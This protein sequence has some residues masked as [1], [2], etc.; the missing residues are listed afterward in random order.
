MKSLH[1]AVVGAGPAGL[2]A[3]ECLAQ[4]GIIVTL[5]DRM[6]SPARKFLL[7]GRGGLNLTHSEAHDAFLTRYGEAHPLMARALQRF[8]PIDLR[9]WAA[10]LGEETFIGSS[11][12]VFP[13]SFKAS[14]LLRAWLKRLADQGVTLATRHEF[15]GF[16]PEGALRFKTPAGEQT[17]KADAVLLALG[18]ASWPRLGADGSW[19]PLLSAAGVTLHPFKPANAGWL[20]PWSAYVRRFAGTPLKRIAV[21]CQGETVRGDA[22][23]TQSG[24]EGG[25]IYALG[26][27]MR[28]ALSASQP[29][30]HLDLRPDLAVAALASKLGAMRQGASMAK[31][32]TQAGL[33]PAMQAI[34]REAGPLPSDADALAQRIKMAPLPVTGFAGLERAISSAGGVTLDAFDDRMMLKARPGL[35]VAG[36]M[37]DW[38]APTGGY[39]LQ[40]CFATAALAADGIAAYLHT[41]R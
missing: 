9:A 23:I 34:L 15:I 28:R 2:F 10:G 25:P 22:M 39:L 29:I 30:I 16:T 20:V 35:F 3:A 1:V 21:T 5:Y 41:Q 14:P 11:G 36:E 26:P 27:V 7:A 31:R 32:L 40:A 8:S 37:L 13:K 33:S 18:G 38:E 24:L 17:I 19:A 12:R 4:K 6:P